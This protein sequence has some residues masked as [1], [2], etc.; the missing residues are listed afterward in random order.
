[1]FLSASGTFTILHF[2]L[3]KAS[4]MRRTN[5]W[6]KSQCYIFKSRTPPMDRSM[7]Y[8]LKRPRIWA[9]QKWSSVRSSLAPEESNCWG[10]LPLSTSSFRRVPKQERAGMEQAFPGLNHVSAKGIPR[11]A[12][13]HRGC[14]HGS[15]RAMLF[16]TS[17][18]IEVTLALS[19]MR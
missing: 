12:S 7:C 3:M 16:K 15:S 1:M 6:E 11:S 2:A 13:Y 17:S 14:A 19:E 5:F 9:A 18:W 4:V 10:I 8:H